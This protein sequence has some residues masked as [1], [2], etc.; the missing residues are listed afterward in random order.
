MPVRPRYAAQCPRCH[1]FA[2]EEGAV[3]I[4]SRAFLGETEHAA[5]AHAVARGWS[6]YPLMCPECNT[7]AKEGLVTNKTAGLY[8]NLAKALNALE[9]AGED[10]G[11]TA[12]E[13]NSADVEWNP[14]QQAWIVVQG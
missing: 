13:G 3:D 1:R 10:P 5:V 6:A 11:R 14:D 2:G 4:P 7:A 9:Q 12:I 8:V